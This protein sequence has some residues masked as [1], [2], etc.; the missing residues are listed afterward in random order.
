ME[1]DA[2]FVSRLFLVCW[3]DVVDEEHDRRHILLFLGLL[4]FWAA[5]AVVVA[6]VLGSVCRSHSLKALP[7]WLSSDASLTTPLL[8]LIT[9]SSIMFTLWM[10]SYCLNWARRVVTVVV[11]KRMRYR[12]GTDIAAGKWSVSACLWSG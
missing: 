5:G 2:I 6:S 10:G 7:A 4:F 1:S 11:F 8:V 9:A 12:R 3:F